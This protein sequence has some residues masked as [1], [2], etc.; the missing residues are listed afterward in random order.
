MEMK[1]NNIVIGKE[2]EY[3]E[4]WYKGHITH[5]ED[6][7]PFWLIYT[8]GLSDATVDYPYR[9]EWFYRSVPRE[10]RAMEEQIVNKFKDQQG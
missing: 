5:E 1:Y 6:I 3:R 2:Y 10:V 4:I 8:E 7:Y 9:I